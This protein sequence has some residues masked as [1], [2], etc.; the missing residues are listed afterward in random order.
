MKKIFKKSFNRLKR[1]NITVDANKIV[2]EYIARLEDLRNK[3]KK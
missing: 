2:N 1:I 3:I